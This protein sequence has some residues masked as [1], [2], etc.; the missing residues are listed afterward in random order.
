MTAVSTRER[1]L[2]TAAG[3]FL[4]RG[5]HATSVATILQES[6]VHPGSLYHCF[7]SKDELLL[8][9]LD[10]YLG[11]LRPVLMDPV[12]GVEADPIERVFRLLA[13]YRLHVESSGFLRGCP[14]GNLALE[15]GDQVPAA[16]ERVELNFE[17]WVDAVAGWIAAGR[18]RLPPATDPR[19]LALF[20]LTT[21]EGG[22]MLARAR[23]SMAPFDAA[24]AMLRE[25]FRLLE[26]AAGG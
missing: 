18:E 2:R 4:E 17:R 14:I 1:L 23:R 20:V 19:A 26:S 16:R 7:A 8:G 5:Y 13:F 15:L 11:Q 22:I 3:L 9:V 10:W 25:H 21:M 12:E 6:G 24:V